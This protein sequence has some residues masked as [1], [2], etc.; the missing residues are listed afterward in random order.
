MGFAALLAM[1]P[2][3]STAPVV[4]MAV[5]RIGNAHPSGVNFG[6]GRSRVTAATRTTSTAPT[7]H[8]IARGPTQPILDISTSDRESGRSLIFGLTAA[9]QSRRL[10]RCRRRLQTLVS[11]QAAVDTVVAPRGKRHLTP[12]SKPHGRRANHERQHKSKL[13]DDIPL[14]LIHISEPTRLLS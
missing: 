14:S 12:S 5:S 8:T 3:T 7:E 1:A 2:N 13:V 9:F 11:R 4:R 6:S 10:Q